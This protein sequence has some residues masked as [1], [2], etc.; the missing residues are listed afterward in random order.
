MPAAVQPCLLPRTGK[1]KGPVN[2]SCNDRGGSAQGIRHGGGDRRGRDAARRAEGPRWRGAA[3][4][5]LEWAAKW[6][7]RTWAVEGAGGLG[8]VLAQQLV[9]AGERVLD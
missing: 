8:H 3:R 4:K 6:P 1:Q 7:H 9:A 5:L 2:G